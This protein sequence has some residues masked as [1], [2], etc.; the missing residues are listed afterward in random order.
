MALLE[1]FRPLA[2][3]A[4]QRQRDALAGFQQARDGVLPRNGGPLP[5]R[6]AFCAAIERAGIR[7]E[8][9]DL[10]RAL[11]ALHAPPPPG[12]SPRALWLR[13]VAKSNEGETFGVELELE[14]FARRGYRGVDP[15]LLAVALE[16]RMHTRLLGAVCR[17][18][19]IALEVAPPRLGSR[20]A[21]RA[22]NHLPERLRFAL[23]LAGEVAG[24]TFFHVLLERTDL[25]ESQ[26]AVREHLGTLIREIVVDETA[27]V[28]YFRA[29]VGRAERRLASALLP[30]LAAALLRDI[31]EFAALGG[32][33]AA[34]LARLRRPL[35]LPSEMRW[36]ADLEADAPPAFSTAPSPL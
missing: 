25:F 18:F 6:E 19:G 27:H 1:P 33:R 24:A 36:L 14:R 23:I 16:D 17:T 29:R 15:S 35:P 13:A 34:L 26:P 12:T 28:A 20:L 10:A 7:W 4:S 3:E 2:P 31:P 22:M 21:I 9:D 5:R 8:G 32:G 11:E 30:G